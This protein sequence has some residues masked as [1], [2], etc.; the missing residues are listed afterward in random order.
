MAIKL[1]VLKSGEDLIADVKEIQSESSEEV[2][3]YYFY[4]PLIL[5]LYSAEE[6]PVVLSEEE[7][8]TTELGTTKEFQSKVGITF[9]PWIP[10]SGTREI[11]CS[12]DWVVTIVDPQE[13]V[14]KM[15]QEKVNGRPDTTATGSDSSDD[16]NS[17]ITE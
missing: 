5:K 11:P 2:I 10:L 3:G 7:G 6:K 4:N 17:V 14:S 13:Q 9:Y 1:V 12:A 16:Q 8:T 15:Y